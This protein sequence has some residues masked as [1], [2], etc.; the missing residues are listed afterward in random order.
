MLEVKFAD[1]DRST[2]SQF[3]ANLLS[4]SPAKTVFTTSTGQFSPPELQSGSNYH[5]DFD[6]HY[7]DCRQCGGSAHDA[8]PV[9]ERLHLPLR[10]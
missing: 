4:T 9:A 2:L 10:H 5:W 6:V 3:G 7:H 8:R 1:V